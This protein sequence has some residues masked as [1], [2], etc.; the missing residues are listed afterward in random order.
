MKRLVPILACCAMLCGCA[1]PYVAM[2]IEITDRD[3]FQADLNE[4]AQ[5][6]ASYQPHVSATAVALGAVGG[7]VNNLVGGVVNPLVP[8]IGAA[9]GAGAALAQGLGVMSQSKRNVAK[10]CMQDKTSRDHSAVLANP[11]D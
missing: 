3:Q 10:H 1:Q 9:G 5:A 11:D 4:C 8:V 2:P 6:A 7:G